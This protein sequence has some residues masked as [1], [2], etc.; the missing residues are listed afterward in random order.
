[1]LEMLG[2]NFK[3]IG[4]THNVVQCGL[5]F[6]LLLWNPN[7]NKQNDQKKKNK[8]ME[9]HDW[10]KYRFCGLFFCGLDLKA[11]EQSADR[12]GKIDCVQ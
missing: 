8:P 5:H 4:T 12:I 2:R 9:L 6:A 1:M 10:L 3:H 11:E 7:Q